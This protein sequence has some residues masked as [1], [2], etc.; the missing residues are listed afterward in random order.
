MAS[1]TR[2]V[3]RGIPGNLRSQRWD[4]A[5][6]RNDSNLPVASGDIFEVADSLG[7]PARNLLV[8]VTGGAGTSVHLR[9]NPRVQTFPRRGENEGFFNTHHLL[10]A[11]GQTFIDTS[12]RPIVLDPGDSLSLREELPI[13]EIEVATISGSPTFTVLVT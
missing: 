12:I 7:R 4:T 5:F 1:I 2:R 9:L 13:R 10:V 6:D 11:S 3:N 8:E